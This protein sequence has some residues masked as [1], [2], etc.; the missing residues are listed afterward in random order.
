VGTLLTV[1]IRQETGPNRWLEL[2]SCRKLK[3]SIRRL[4]LLL[5]QFGMGHKRNE[6][7]ILI[8]AE[9]W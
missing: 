8:S 9:P 1:E 6:D 7:N 4:I 3:Q 2:A 5:L